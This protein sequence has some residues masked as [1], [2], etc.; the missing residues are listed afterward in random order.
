MMKSIRIIMTAFAFIAFIASPVMAT[1]STT[2]VSAACDGRILGIPPWY[3][4]LTEGDDCH[5]KAPGSGQNG[6]T[7][8]ITKLA[9]NII[10]MVMVVTAYIASFFILY[11]GYMFVA[12]NGTSSVVERATRTI[13]NAVIGLLISLA[14]VGLVNFVF[15]II[16]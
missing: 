13:L 2:P 8:F 11:G 1:I 12:N 14:A 15:G 5:I 16:E 7:K 3:R 4:G 9:L 10:E 6:M